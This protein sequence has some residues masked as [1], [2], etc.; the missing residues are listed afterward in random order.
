MGRD[1]LVDLPARQAAGVPAHQ[2][3]QRRFGRVA[4]GQHPSPV[5][6]AAHQCGGVGPPAQR[7]LGR[8]QVRAPQQ[9]PGVEQDDRGVAT[10]RDR[11]GARGGHHDGRLARDVGQHAFTGGRLQDPD[12]RQRAAQLL[13][14]AGVAQHRSAQCLAAALR[15]GPGVLDGGAPRALGRAAWAALAQRSVAHGAQGGVAAAAAREPRRVAHAGCLHEDGALLDR[16]PHQPQR[17]A[18]QARRAG[19]GVPV[20]VAVVVAAQVHRDPAAHH[21][22]RG[23]DLGGPAGAQEVLRLDAAG[24]R[25]EHRRA[26]GLLGAQE[27]DLAGVGV[28]RPRLV[29]QVVAVVPH[30]HQAQVADRREGRRPGADHDAHR[31]AA[32][33]QERPVALGRAGVGRQHDVASLPHPPGQGA[34]EPVEVAVVGHADQRPAPRRGGGD[35]RLGQHVAPVVARHDAPDHPGVLPR[36]QPGQGLGAAGVVREPLGVRRRV[37]RRGRRRGL[38]LHVGVPRGDGQA[39]DVGARPGVP[40]RDGGGQGRDVGGEHLLGADHLAQRR[41]AAGVLGRRRPLQHE[42]VDV[43]AREAHLDAHARLRGLGHGRGDGVVEG[44]VEVRQR[45]VDQHP[46]HRVDLGSRDGL[47]LGGRRRPSCDLA[48]PC[49]RR[50]QLELLLLRSRRHRRHSLTRPRHHP[51]SGSGPPPAQG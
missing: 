35:N 33:R 6:G 10:V 43:L 37:R 30:R 24:V 47:L 40:P 42:P 23:G 3:L 51:G 41:E 44:P 48:R 1:P 29:E 22:A 28:R 15:A 25:G 4:D 45:H 27:E 34:V 11:L 5:T 21:V 49:G 7:L 31:A 14:G 18:G 13:G 50:E 39:E 8:T 2:G 32:Q 19:G 9:Q 38:L 36:G 12:A 17:L 16:R 46:R 20:E 26:A